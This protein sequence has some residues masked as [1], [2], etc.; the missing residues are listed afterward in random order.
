MRKLTKMS[1]M[2]LAS[3][4]ILTGCGGDKRLRGKK[5]TSN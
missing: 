3:G 2:L 5:K 4:L 1:A